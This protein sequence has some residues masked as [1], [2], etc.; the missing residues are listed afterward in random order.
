MNSTYFFRI[1]DELCI[2]ATKKSNYGRFI[3]HC[4]DVNIN[5]F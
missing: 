4:C 2:D 1:D 3:N 5:F